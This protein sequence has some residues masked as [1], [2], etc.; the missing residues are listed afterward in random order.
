MLPLTAALPNQQSAAGRIEIGAC[1]R[2]GGMLT[3]PDDP[4]RAIGNVVAARLRQ[5]AVGIS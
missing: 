4:V 5:A 1:R 2:A 3:L